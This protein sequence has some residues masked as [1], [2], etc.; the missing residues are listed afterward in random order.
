[1]HGVLIS[2]VSGVVL[3]AAG[4]AQHAFSERADAG[5]AAGQAA[6]AVASRAADMQGAV[7]VAYVGVLVSVGLHVLPLLWL[8]TTQLAVRCNSK[9]LELLVTVTV[10][11]AVLC[12][13]SFLQ[14]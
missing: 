11:V 6:T 12:P 8:C 4:R 14:E 1:M 5:T 7:H 10:A 13:V 3:V 9:R 2:V